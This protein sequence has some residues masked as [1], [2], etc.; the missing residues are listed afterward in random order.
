MSATVV[1]K[2]KNMHVTCTFSF[3]ARTAFKAVLCK[4]KLPR[5]EVQRASIKLPSKRTVL[6]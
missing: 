5:P 2:T 3:K 4:G 1:L 6:F